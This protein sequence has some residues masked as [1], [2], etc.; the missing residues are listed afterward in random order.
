M[1]IH[2]PV[3]GIPQD[4]R[5]G[6]PSCGAL[7]VYDL[8]PFT[9]LDYPGYTACIIWFAGCN[10]RC[11]YCHNPEIVLSKGR[12][13]PD[14]IFDFLVR[15]RGLLD[16]VVLS[17]GEAS[18]YPGLLDFIPWIK[19]MGYR[20]KIDTNG[21]HPEK[22][23]TLHQMGMLDYLALD[24]KAPPERFR[25]VTAT[26]KYVEFSKTLDYLCAHMPDAFEVR[27]T[28]HTDLLDEEDI[29]WILRDLDRRGYRGKYALQNYTQSDARPTLGGMGPQSRILDRARLIQP[30][31]ARIEFRNF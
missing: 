28:V 10:M 2:D 3:V 8:T 9:M 19:N 16:A 14:Y 13:K 30:Q 24:Y 27:T 25:L 31:Q 22:I 12:V 20:I 23:I 21:L 11:P 4:G 18:A 29:N 7:P 6:F 1:L 17:G 15:R 5:G 26:G